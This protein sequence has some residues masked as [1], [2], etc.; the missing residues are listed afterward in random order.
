MPLIV[1]FTTDAKKNDVKSLPMSFPLGSRGVY[2]KNPSSSA[3][4]TACMPQDT[5][6][7]LL[8]MNVKLW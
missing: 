3:L 1:C 8:D 6:Q 7:S 5:P 2:V 4:S